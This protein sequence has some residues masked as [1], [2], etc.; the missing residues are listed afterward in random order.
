MWLALQTET[1]TC[2]R[3]ES[4]CSTDSLA[5]APRVEIDR[6]MVEADTP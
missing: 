3:A 2:D 4:T 6:V 1:Q 5:A